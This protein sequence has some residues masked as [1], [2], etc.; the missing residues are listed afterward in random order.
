MKNEEVFYSNSV[1]EIAEIR[2]I[3]LKEKINFTIHLN[4]NSHPIFGTNLSKKMQNILYKYVITVAED[5][6]DKALKILE[7]FFD[8]YNT[9]ENEK[10][11]TELEES[12][13]VEKNSIKESLSEISISLILLLIFQH[14]SRFFI[15]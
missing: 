9:K 3:L 11:Y 10:K 12:E 8:Q 15:M 14:Y 2:E 4:V 7:T 1:D 6:K 13:E 5:D